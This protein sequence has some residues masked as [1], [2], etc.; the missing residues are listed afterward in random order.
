M[1][2]VIIV[3]MAKYTCILVSVS[4]I[5]G[6]YTGSLLCFNC[7]H[8]VIITVMRYKVSWSGDGAVSGGSLGPDSV[9]VGIRLNPMPQNM[10][11]KL[12]REN[13]C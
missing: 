13:R 5:S 7:L 11:W 8:E 12:S 9:F 1:L 10:T 4:K 6:G 3:N 2:Y